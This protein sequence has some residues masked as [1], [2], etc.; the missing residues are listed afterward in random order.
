MRVVHYINQF[1]AGV[2]GEDSAA[3]G[4]ASSAEAKGPGRKLAGLLGPDHQVVATVWCGDD[5]AVGTAGAID[6]ILALVQ[7]AEPDLVVAGPAF[8]SGRYGLACARVVAAATA[9]GLGAVASMH[10]DNPGLDEAGTA[11]VVASGEVARSMGPSLETLA[12]AAATLLAG[13]PLTTE[14]GR[15]GRLPRQSVLDDRNAATRAVDLVLARLGGDRDAT[16]VPLPRFDQVTPAA[17]VADPSVVTVAFVTEGGLVPDANPGG[18]ES[19][20]ATRWLRYPIEDRAGLEPGEWRS[21]HGGFSTVFAN[22][23]PNRILP[24]DV[25]R[26]LEGEGR[27]GALMPEYFVTTGNGTSVANARRFG[28]EWAADIRRSGARAAILTST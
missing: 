17:P 8:T 10:P 27:I 2:G 23:D 7:A 15:I 26:E 19:A 18:L 3:T 1:F 9:A 28:V 4:P 20:R 12:G 14:E 25:A 6:E 16:E 13:E 21:V 11:P 24:L 22:A 5:Y